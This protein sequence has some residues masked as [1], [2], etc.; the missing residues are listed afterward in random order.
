MHLVKAGEKG[1]E[2]VKTW[3]VRPSL[4]WAGDDWRP[5]NENS[6]KEDEPSSKRPKVDGDNVKTKRQEPIG[7]DKSLKKSAEDCKLISDPPGPRVSRRSSEAQKNASRAITT[8]LGS[9]KCYKQTERSSRQARVLSTWNNLPIPKKTN[10]SC[11]SSTSLAAK[12]GTIS[13][14]SQLKIEAEKLKNFKKL[15]R[16]VIQKGVKTVSTRSDTMKLKSKTIQTKL[17]KA[18]K[19]TSHRKVPRL[20]QK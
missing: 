5:W 9:K 14:R 1:I 13:T 20:A 8:S 11:P 2:T 4:I 18:L 16:M 19:K 12:T 3:D 6:A 15:S 17:F 10:G 7:K